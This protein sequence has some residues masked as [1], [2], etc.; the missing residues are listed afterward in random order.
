MKQSRRS[1]LNKL[2]RVNR[3]NIAKILVLTIGAV[4]FL[5]PLYWM[6]VTSLKTTTGDCS[7]ST[8]LVAG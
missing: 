8:Y 1:T 2:C 7:L 4:I 3:I 6:F 5:F